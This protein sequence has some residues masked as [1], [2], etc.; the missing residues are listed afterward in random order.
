MIINE[1]REIQKLKNQL[2]NQDN[3]IEKL[4]KKLEEK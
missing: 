4:K 1:Q 2:K 3:E